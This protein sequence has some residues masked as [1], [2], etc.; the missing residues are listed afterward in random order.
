[1]ILSYVSV[2]VTYHRHIP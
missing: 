1:M 2:L